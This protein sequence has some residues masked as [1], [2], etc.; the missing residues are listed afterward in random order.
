MEGTD[1]AVRRLQRLEPPVEDDPEVIAARREIGGQV[2]QQFLALSPNETTLAGAALA[3]LF[4]EL[5]RRFE[6]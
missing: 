3:E 5:A 1:N 4:H 6:E 2:F